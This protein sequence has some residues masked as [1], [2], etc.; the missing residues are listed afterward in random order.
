MVLVAKN[1]AASLGDVRETDLINGL[2]SSLGVGNGNPL[3]NWLELPGKSHGQKSLAD[4]TVHSVT[5]NQTQL[6]QLSMHTHENLECHTDWIY[7][8]LKFV[9]V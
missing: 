9:Y 8:V 1:L 6:E 2:G 5:K 7:P 4:Y 3:Q